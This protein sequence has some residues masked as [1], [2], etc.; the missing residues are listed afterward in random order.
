MHAGNVLT[1]K[2]GCVALI[3]FGLTVEVDRETQVC[4]AK[5]F[6]SIATRDGAEAADAI[7]RSAQ[8]VHD[9]FD[10]DH[11]RRELQSLLDGLGR[12]A[13]NF[14]VA[15]FVAEL[16]RIQGKCGLRSSSAFT[17]PILALFAFEGLV[18]S[19]APELDFQAEA[20]PFVVSALRTA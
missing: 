18:K 5:L 11:F 10:A 6:L 7:K 1:D 3:D 4:L 13:K 8:V 20:V 15:G 14:Q 12:E 19:L 17:L 16:F 9:C 2:A